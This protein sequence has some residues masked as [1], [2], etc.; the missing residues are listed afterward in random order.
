MAG[1][2]DANASTDLFGG[3]G[4]AAANNPFTTPHQNNRYSADQGLGAFAPSNPLGNVVNLFANSAGTDPFGL[5]SSF[6][7]PAPA[8]VADSFFAG[9]GAF[10]AAAASNP[11][12]VNGGYLGGVAAANP[13]AQAPAPV[14]AADQWG[15]FAGGAAPAPANQF[16]PAASDPF[17]L[18]GLGAPAAAL[19]P[20]D[21]VQDKWPVCAQT[22]DTIYGCAWIDN[23][24][25]VVVGDA[26]GTL[27]CVRV[28]GAQFQVLPPIQAAAPIT[29]IVCGRV[30]AGVF[31]ADSTGNV[32]QWDLGA[33]RSSVL[34]P[35][36]H[37]LAFENSR[38]VL[39][40][41][42]WARHLAVKDVRQN[43]QALKVPL[44]GKCHC[45][46]IVGD[47]VFAGVNKDPQSVAVMLFDLRNTSQPI[48]THRL[49]PEEG[50]V[51]TVLRR[52]TAGGFVY[53]TANGY[54]GVN[55]GGQNQTRIT[56]LARLKLQQQQ[57]QQ[58]DPLGL[59]M[60]VAAPTRPLN[61]MVNKIAFNPV[62]KKTCV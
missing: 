20:R 43:G 55:I 29:N 14:P 1:W 33:K 9:A 60:S 12:E 31:V 57:Q 47:L 59:S 17:A 49:Q 5:G 40:A 8:P 3:S 52:G 45:V 15:A 28:D 18:G 16:A 21:P 42:S 27:Q 26:A 6:P 11:F 35:F 25:M 56:D 22:K 51:R 34:G 4:G 46:D 37:A 13:F 19:P 2:W 38:S 24:N 53:G 32:T 36:G 30:A 54:I 23:P 58:L 39:V 50:M 44:A 61:L 62:D 41:G 48:K 10:N 7:A